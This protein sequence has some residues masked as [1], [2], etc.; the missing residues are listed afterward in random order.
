MEAI[1]N[2]PF[3]P[4]SPIL[5]P[6]TGVLRFTSPLHGYIMQLQS[7]I[8]TVELV[9]GPVDPRLLGT[10]DESITSSFQKHISGTHSLIRKQLS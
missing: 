7:F 6:L 4:P 2:L 5:P 10:V 8:H 9:D 1:L 3:V